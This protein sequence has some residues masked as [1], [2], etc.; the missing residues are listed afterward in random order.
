MN[1]FTAI[2]EGESVLRIKQ[3]GL[4]SSQKFFSPGKSNNLSPLS[5]THLFKLK[6]T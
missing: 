1:T 2:T 3:G 5:S 4:A 6:K